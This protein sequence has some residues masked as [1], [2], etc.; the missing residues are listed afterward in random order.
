MCF[1]GALILLRGLGFGARKDLLGPL[2]SRVGGEGL[3]LAV[4]SDMVENVH[5]Y[6]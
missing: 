1:L 3:H 2:G 6:R 4:V 5:L